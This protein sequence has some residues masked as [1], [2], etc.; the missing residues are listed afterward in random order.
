MPEIKEIGYFNSI[1]VKSAEFEETSNA[2]QKRFY[3]EESRI[4]GGFNE[5]AMDQGVRAYLVNDEYTVINRKNAMIYSGIYNAKTGVNELNQFSIGDNITKA[6]DITD[7]SIQK[8]H[9]EDRELFILQEDKCNAAGINKD[10]IFTA[11]GQPLRTASNIVIGQVRTFLGIYGISKNPESFAVKGNRKYFTDEKRGVVLRLTRDGLTEISNYGMRD[12]F[13]DNLKTNTNLIGMYDNVKDQY[14]L[15]LKQTGNTVAFDET[16]KGWTSF[17][18]YYPENGFTLNNKFYTFNKGNIYVHYKNTDYNV[19]YG[20]PAAASSI[21]AIMNIDGSVVKTF[22]TLGYEGTTGWSANNIKT[23]LD[24]SNYSDLA[25]NIAKYEYNFGYDSNNEFINILP[26]MF[27][28]KEG[29]YFS[30]LQ[31]ASIDAQEDEILFGAGVSGVKGMYLHTTL[32]TKENSKQ[33]LFTILSEVVISS[34]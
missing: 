14:I 23:D 13:K 10:F 6:V 20:Q 5:A 30:V 29:K 25:E 33:E 31:N 1:F 27:V 12:Y 34:K 2:N 9:A 4:K 11:E 22:K 19:F 15:H 18:S 24:N 26:S 17:Y 21:T 32:E 28:K 16:S 7:G 3:I 8:L